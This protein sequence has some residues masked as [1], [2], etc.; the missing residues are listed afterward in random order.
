[1]SA[2]RRSPIVLTI[3]ASEIGMRAGSE[4]CVLDDVRVEDAAVIGTASAYSPP[5]RYRFHL[6]TWVRLTREP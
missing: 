5:P 2:T 6:P 4:E 3:G 1:M